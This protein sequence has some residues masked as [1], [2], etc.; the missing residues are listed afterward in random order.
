GSGDPAAL[1]A[2]APPPGPAPPAVHPARGAPADPLLAMISPGPEAEVLVNGTRIDDAE[3]IVP[4]DLVQIGGVMLRIGMAPVPDADL[5]PVVGGRGFNRPSRVKPDAPQPV[6]QLPGDKPA[7]QDQSPLPWLSAVI[8]VIMGVTM[9]IV[10][11][12]P[13]ML[14]M[15]AASPIMVVGS[16]ITQRRLA[17]KKG[18]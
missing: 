1:R 8:P 10:F 9:A 4:A 16:F 2:A 14:M 15:A 12:R 7:D 17:K 13:I 5:T 6:I 18:V 3:R 11:Q